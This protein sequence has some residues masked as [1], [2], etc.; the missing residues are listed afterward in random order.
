MDSE[1]VFVERAA[2]SV[3]NI[4][5][6]RVRGPCCDCGRLCCHDKPRAVEP[7]RVGDVCPACLKSE[8]E[9]RGASFSL[10]CEVEV[11]SSARGR[12]GSTR[13]EEVVGGSSA[14]EESKLSCSEPRFSRWAD[15]GGGVLAGED[16]SGDIERARSVQN[17]EEQD[18]KSQQGSPFLISAV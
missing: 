17:G 4:E 12:T 14:G 3:A 15:E 16:F 6:G 5:S 18:L 11:I 8:A 7:L 2:F 1:G 10:V 9:S 13:G